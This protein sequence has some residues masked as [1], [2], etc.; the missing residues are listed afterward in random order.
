MDD[1]G[2][3]ISFLRVAPFDS[4]GFFDQY[5]TNPI[6]Y[7]DT[8]GLEKLKRL[9]QSTS[10]RRT[11][12]SELIRL[13]P[14]RKNIVQSVKLNEEERKFHNFFTKRV[15]EIA[16]SDSFEAHKYKGTG[17]I[18]PTLTKLRQ[19]CNHGS[20]LLSA[21]SLA[22]LVHYDHSS[23]TSDAFLEVESCANCG[24]HLD[25]SNLAGTSN[26]RLPHDQLICENC[27][28]DDES[29]DTGIHNTEYS[30]DSSQR[31]KDVGMEYEQPAA[32]VYDV[33]K[34]S[35]KVSALIENIR[36]D[37][38]DL[39]LPPS[40]RLGYQYIYSVERSY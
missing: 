15:S 20:R 26:C 40:K 28:L 5:I 1:Y 6:R 23:V 21:A 38:V 29:F 12:E 30:S 33:Y 10:L 4:R 36:K 11:K 9:V 35:S 34:P 3:L 16:F 39:S 25:A 18:F 7:N 37:R 2:A 19:I 8:G 17:N 14:L 31:W 27:A 13:L 22:A 32:T 24:D